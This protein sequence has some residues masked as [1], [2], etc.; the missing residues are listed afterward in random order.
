M[1]LAWAS[2]ILLNLGLLLRVVGEP[3]TSTYPETGTGWLL[4]VSALLQWLA[5]ILFV[6]L[7]AAGERAVSRR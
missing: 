6:A 1:K 5:A 7:A 4:V 2:Y 3:L